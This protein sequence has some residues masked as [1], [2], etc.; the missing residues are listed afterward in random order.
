MYDLGQMFKQNER[1]ILHTLILQP[2]NTDIQIE[3]EGCKEQHCVADFIPA[4]II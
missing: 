2:Q 3:A 4:L 1:F